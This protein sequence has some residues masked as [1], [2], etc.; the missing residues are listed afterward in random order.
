[1]LGTP[2]SKEH[3]HPWRSI[4][5]DS[6]DGLFR[7]DAARNPSQRRQAQKSDLPYN[8]I[9]GGE[10]QVKNALSEFFLWSDLCDQM[11]FF[12]AG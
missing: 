12:L 1:M 7:L 4:Y 6:Y 2:T 10:C 11:K 5:S 8:K 3:Q 9:F